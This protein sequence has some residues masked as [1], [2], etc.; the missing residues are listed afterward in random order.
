MSCGLFSTKWSV[1]EVHQWLITEGIPNV[2]ADVFKSEVVVYSIRTVGV[3]M[4][5]LRMIPSH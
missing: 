3:A 2:V 5:F 1:D 4:G